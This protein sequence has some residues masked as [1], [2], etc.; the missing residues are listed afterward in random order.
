MVRY[1]LPSGQRR[2]MKLGDV[3]GLSLA[4]AR[5]R[6]AQIT[7][8]A[9]DGHD[10]QEQREA[11]KRQAADTFGA[12][13][14]LYLARYAARE[15]KP[16]TLVETTRALRVHLAPLHGRPL[17][18]ITRRDVAAR[19]M[20][21]VDSSGPIMANRTPR[22]PVPLLRLGDAAGPR[23]GQSGHRYRAPCA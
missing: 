16:R 12:L 5:K 22:G 6:A 9:K 18:D 4:E 15:Q 21:L 17:A 14:D 7:S 2:K 11:R 23:R 10:P 20:E 13:V 19:L 1:Q 8:G 3:A